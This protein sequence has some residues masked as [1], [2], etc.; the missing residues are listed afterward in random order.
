MPA[1]RK[2]SLTCDGCH[3][4]DKDGSV[5]LN[6]PDTTVHVCHQEDFDKQKASMC[7]PCHST[8]PP[9][10]SSDLIPYPLYKKERAMLFQFSHAQ[11]IDPQGRIDPQTHSRA[12]CSFCH[13][14]DSEG[15][16]ATF[17][18]HPQCAAC[19]SKAGMKPLLSPNSVTADC[20]GCHHAGRDSRIPAMPKSTHDRGRTGFWQV[21]KHKVLPRRALQVPRSIQS[22]VHH[23]S[24]RHHR[25]H[26]PRQHEPAE[27]DRLRGMP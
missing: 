20:R 5:V 2:R 12:D 24:R 15:A 14:L 26:Q 25:Q 17:P 7:A 21:R 3:V 8:F 13:Q 23:L 22:R 9:K 11:H 10:D 19:H 27:D 6:V 4:A 1:I 16:F 18:T